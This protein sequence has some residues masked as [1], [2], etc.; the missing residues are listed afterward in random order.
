M[1]FR[2]RRKRE[3][4]LCRQVMHYLA[5]KYT[6]ISL[7]KLG[8]LLHHGKAFDHSSLIHSIRQISNQMEYDDQLS[9]QVESLE[10]MLRQDE[11]RIRRNTA[12]A[13][14]VREKIKKKQHK[15]M[16]P[17]KADP[18][19]FVRSTFQAEHERVIEKYAI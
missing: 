7:V 6:D 17:V 12:L 8:A 2:K 5:Y 19:P 16:E 1:V 18:V 14:V 15:V 9:A 3:V 11:Y 13:K 4:V 10:C